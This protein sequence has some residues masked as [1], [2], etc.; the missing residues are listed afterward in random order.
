MLYVGY[1]SS[2]GYQTESLES[3]ATT[4]GSGAVSVSTLTSDAV[5]ENGLL[6]QLTLMARTCHFSLQ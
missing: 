2:R 1:L 3:P 6:I 5:P 4:L